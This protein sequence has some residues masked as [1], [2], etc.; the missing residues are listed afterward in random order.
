MKQ[1]YID[2]KIECC[3]QWYAKLIRRLIR[4]NAK[5]R[6]Q[7]LTDKF[8]N[9][10]TIKIYNS[11]KNAFE[12]ISRNACVKYLERLDKRYDA[13]KTMHPN[14]FYKEIRKFEDIISRTKINGKM[15]IDGSKKDSLASQII[16]ALNYKEIRNEIYP[17]IARFLELKT[18]VYCNANFTISAEKNLG[19][20][21]LDHW[22]P[23]T[24]Y[25]YLSTSFFNLQPCCSPCNRRKS[26][27]DEEYFCLWTDNPYAS[28]DIFN[29]N[30]T[31]KSIIIYRMTHNRNDLIPEFY[32][33]KQKYTKMLA[34]MQQRLHIEERYKEHLDVAEEIIWRSMV[35]NLSMKKALRKS[36]SKISTSDSEF[37]RFILGTYND[38]DD[39]HKR[40]LTIFRQNIAK[41]IG[42]I[43]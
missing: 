4:K 16:K 12:P 7:K 28:T 15:N 8:K 30:L 35:Y 19:F 41:R 42:L 23:K 6:I 21:E 25:P 33:K 5:K 37:H 32:I 38:L 18:C 36:F 22:K 40:P 17:R 27:D 43:R 13:L 10:K 20:F 39:V 29:V 9:Y 1:I 24:L 11:S 31:R 26:D 14:N 3:A 34:V 2:E